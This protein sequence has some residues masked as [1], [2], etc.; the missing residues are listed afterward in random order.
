[1]EKSFLVQ[2][3]FGNDDAVVFELCYSKTLVWNPQFNRLELDDT[4]YDGVIKWYVNNYEPIQFDSD[5]VTRDL[6]QLHIA[7]S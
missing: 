6:K 5:I 3:I 1:M 2:V 7:G 4:V